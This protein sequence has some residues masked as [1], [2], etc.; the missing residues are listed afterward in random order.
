MRVT[1]YV[2]VS[3]EGVTVNAFIE[4]HKQK[5]FNYLQN[6]FLSGALLTRDGWMTCDFMSFSTL[7]QSYQDNGRMINERL[8]AV[9]PHFT[10]EKISPRAGLKPRTVRSVRQGLTH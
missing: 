2:L 7:F 6:P 10:V 5:M 9:E 4:K 1:T 3:N 8:C